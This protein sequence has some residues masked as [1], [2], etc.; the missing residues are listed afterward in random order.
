MNRVPKI[1]RGYH[2]RSE[3]VE[4]L[5]M[6]LVINTIPSQLSKLNFIITIMLLFPVVV[7]LSVQLFLTL[8]ESKHPEHTVIVHLLSAI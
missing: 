6:N 2:R 8:F 4:T 3:R 1:Y 7:C 5:T